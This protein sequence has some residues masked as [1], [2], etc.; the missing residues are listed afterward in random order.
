MPKERKPTVYDGKQVDWLEFAKAQAVFF[1]NV[2]QHIYNLQ[3]DIEDIDK[4]INSILESIEHGSYNCVQG[5]QVFRQLKDLRLQRKSFA[6]EYQILSVFSENFNCEEM[7]D[8]Y[9]YTVGC[10]EALGF[11]STPVIDENTGTSE[12]AAV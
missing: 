4:E 1:A 8:A 10:I 6:Q 5:Y 12:L 9:E 11:D 3:T 7:L 2:Q